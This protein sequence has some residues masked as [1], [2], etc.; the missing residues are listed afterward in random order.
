MASFLE[1]VRL[2][3]EHA[4]WENLSRQQG[5]GKKNFSPAFHVLEDMEEMPF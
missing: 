5:K 4:G 2:E 1:E 3:M